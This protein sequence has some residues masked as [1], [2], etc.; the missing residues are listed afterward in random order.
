MTTCAH[1]PDELYV[2]DADVA[3]AVDPEHQERIVEFDVC[4]CGPVREEQSARSRRCASSAS[5]SSAIA[6]HP[7]PT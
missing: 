1:A 2:H 7:P 4:Y 3:L 6:S 5:R